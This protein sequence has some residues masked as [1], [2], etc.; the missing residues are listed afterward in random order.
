MN[1][2]WKLAATGQ[3]FHFSCLPC[4]NI[5]LEEMNRYFGERNADEMAQLDS[6]GM[7][8]FVRELDARIRRRL[9]GANE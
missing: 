5:K 2:P 1:T 6:E 9:Q 8:E 7:I 4:T 3:R